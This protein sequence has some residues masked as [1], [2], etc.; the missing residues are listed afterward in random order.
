MAL[1]CQGERTKFDRFVNPNVRGAQKIVILVYLR[2]LPANMYVL[3]I[4]DI[5]SDTAL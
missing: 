1:L 5:C 3:Y 4:S 2:R